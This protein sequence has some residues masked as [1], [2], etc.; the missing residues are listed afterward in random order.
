MGLQLVAHYYDRVEGLIAFSTIDAAGIPV[1]LQSAM[2][3]SVD[4]CYLGAVG[5]YR[6]V[7][8]DEDVEAAV[9]ILHEARR[10]PL[11]EGE[12]LEVEFG[13]LQGLLT[14]LVGMAADAPA[15]I[16][17]RKWRD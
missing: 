15:T 1:F 17:G 11:Q 16:R 10:N 12:T 6:L 2:L 9:A 13:F 8:C 5:G 14:F 4:P 7:V 3:L